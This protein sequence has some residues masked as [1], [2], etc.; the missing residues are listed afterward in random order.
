[1][2]PHDAE[3]AE[4]KIKEA[5]NAVIEAATASKGEL[6]KE[7]TDAE[8]ELEK[9]ESLIEETKEEPKH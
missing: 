5:Q 2:E 9:A 3:F 8:F 4:K 7:L 1:M 6:R